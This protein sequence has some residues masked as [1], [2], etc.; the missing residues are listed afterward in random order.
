MNFLAMATN[1][2]DYV[3]SKRSVTETLQGG[4]I[5]SNATLQ[6]RRM[7]GSANR[8]TKNDL[9]N[10]PK[11]S[12]QKGPSNGFGSFKQEKST[13]RLYGFQ[14]RSGGARRGQLDEDEVKDDLFDTASVAQEDFDKTLSSGGFDLDN[15]AQNGE[16]GYVDGNYN[17]H[18]SLYEHGSFPAEVGHAQ[19]AEET[20]EEQDGRSVEEDDSED[21]DDQTV[22]GNEMGMAQAG[23]LAQNWNGYRSNGP[24]HFA[25][26]S[27]PANGLAHYS[28]KSSVPQQQAYR[29]PVSTHNQPV[30]RQLY[31]TNG[32][33]S[34]MDGFVQR[35]QH[36]LPPLQQNGYENRSDG[37][38]G[39]LQ[40]FQSGLSPS[41]TPLPEPLPDYDEKLLYQMD[42]TI[43]KEQPFDAKPGDSTSS[44][45]SAN[46]LPSAEA[47]LE[48]RLKQLLDQPRSQQEEHFSRMSKEDWEKSGDWFIDQFADLMKQMREARQAKRDISKR[49]EDEISAREAAVRG[50]TM[51]ID[52]VLRKMKTGGET[53][54]RQKI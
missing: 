8:L 32:Q 15:Q 17:G 48:D 9:S 41:R 45:P 24:S 39:E 50:K 6:D 21:G 34:P 5:P 47:S 19:K 20:D 53:V 3:T 14:A 43:L 28:N 26:V 35:R 16:Y 30:P 31:G 51:G 25:H 22:N 42:Y 46:G 2:K 36:D 54:L 1:V 38:N 13:Q 37:L 44:Q 4:S 29:T 33:S 12:A 11:P 52:Q 23:Q 18:Q 10:L 40:Q 7:R 27:S 49:F